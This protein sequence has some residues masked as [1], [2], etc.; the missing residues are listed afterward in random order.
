MKKL[1]DE[2]AKLEKDMKKEGKKCHDIVENLNEARDEIL[3]L[4]QTLDEQKETEKE[5]I[6]K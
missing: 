3:E 1:K 5:L 4:K 2:K 6:D